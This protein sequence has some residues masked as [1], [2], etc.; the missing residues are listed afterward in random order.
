MAHCLSPEFNLELFCFRL[1]AQEGQKL[2]PEAA[3]DAVSREIWAARRH[4]QNK[5]K[6]RDF[7]AGSKGRLYCDELQSLVSLLVN[8]APPS[9]LRQGFLEDVRPLVLHLLKGWEIGE[10]RRIFT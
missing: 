8:G 3:L 6:E 5:T 2:N 9:Q 10:L 4:P 7:R 1:V